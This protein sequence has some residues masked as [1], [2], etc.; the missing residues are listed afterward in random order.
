MRRGYNEKIS[1][2]SAIACGR[3]GTRYT[4]AESMMECSRKENNHKKGKSPR[5]AGTGRAAGIT[6][7]VE[8]QFGTSCCAIRACP[9]L[10]P[11]SRD[12]V[13]LILQS[14]QLLYTAIHPHYNIAVLW[15]DI[16][17][18]VSSTYCR[19]FYSLTPN[20]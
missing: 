11:S 8:S 17:A 9:C 19:A 16:K 7:F 2:V 1:Y 12:P 6:P 5:G 15:A 4:N 10:L 20:Y 14:S 13:R 18:D 3:D